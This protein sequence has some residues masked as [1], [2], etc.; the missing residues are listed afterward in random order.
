VNNDIIA[1]RA[2]D[3]VPAAPSAPPPQTPTLPPATPNGL[4][5]RRRKGDGWRN[6]VSTFLILLLAPLVAIVLTLFV[7][8]SYQVDGPSMQPTLHNN[9]R[10]IVLKLPKTWARITGHN[11]IPDRGDIIIFTE[12]NLSEL[13]SS[14][15][16]QLVKRVIGLPGD[17]VVIQ[18]DK[19][20]I[21][22]SQHPNGFDPD[23]TLPY[24]LNPAVASSVSVTT[25]N[26]DIIVPPNEVYVC[27]DNRTNSLDSRYFGTVPTSDIVGKL[28]LRIFPLSTTKA[29]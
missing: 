11:Y 3:Y 15:P 9:D 25:G 20:T 19:I 1:S 13:G 4:G 23:T 22:N 7:F 21:Y 12:N 28:V 14:T 26:V 17:R 16:K 5:R 8:Q 18:N 29:F 2:Q 10:L 27:G 6:F 24:G